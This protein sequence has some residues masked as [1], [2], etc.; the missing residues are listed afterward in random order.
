MKKLLSAPGTRSS[1]VDLAGDEPLDQRLGGD[2][3]QDDLVRLPDDRVGHGLANPDPGQ[4]GDL[5]VE[6]L[7]VLH[8]DGREHVDPGG[9][10][11]LDVLVALGV[12]EPGSVGVRQ[13][14][15][16]GQLGRAADDRRQIHLLEHRVAVR[17]APPR[18]RLEPFGLGNGLQAAVRLEVTDH[19]VTPVLGLRLALAQHLVGLADAGGHP[20]EDLVVPVIGH[21][22]RRL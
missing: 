22:P 20:Q 3:D 5:V 21:A 8:V 9:E 13:L 1:G 6:A 18:D 12:L 19:D 2:V 11:V 16:Q 14:V 15:D 4:L 7:E 10:H 17:H